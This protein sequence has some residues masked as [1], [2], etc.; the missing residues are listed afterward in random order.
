MEAKLQEY[1]DGCGVVIGASGGLGQETARRMAE[2]GADLVLTYREREQPLLELKQEIEAL[3]RKVITARCDTTDLG[4]VEAV[5][6][7]AH[8][9]FGRVHSVVNATGKAYAYGKL[10]RLA[11]ASLREVI[12]TDVIGFFNVA[13]AAVPVL[14]EGGGG[15]IVTVGT[16][17]I[18]RTSLGNSLSAVPK[19]AVAMMVRLLALEEGGN[20]IRVNM[21]GSGAFQAGMSLVMAAQNTVGNVTMDDFAKSATALRRA[22]QPGEFGSLVAFLTTARASYITGQIV[23]VDG[24]LSV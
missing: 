6:A 15:S 7:G 4:S 22:G 16:A 5:F 9:R 21:V 20:G 24:G 19:S 13:K 17:S 12:D 8:D 23:H 2:L 1:P 14:R 10:I 3:G 11:E 18:D